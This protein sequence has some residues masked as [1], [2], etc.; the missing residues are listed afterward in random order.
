VNGYLQDQV[1]YTDKILNLN[2]LLTLNDNNNSVGMKLIQ[3]KNLLILIIFVSLFSGCRSSA[4]E[5]LSMQPT[6]GYPWVTKVD[7]I[8]QILRNKCIDTVQ[9]EAGQVIADIGAGNGY[10]E[11]MLSIFNDSLTFYIQDIDSSVC[12]QRVIDEVTEFYEEVKGSPFSNKFIVVNGTDSSTNLPP[13]V[14]DKIFMFSTY[15]YIKMPDEFMA[16]VRNS[17]KDDGILYV[18]N[19]NMDDPEWAEKIKREYGWNA[20][21]ISQQINDIT[22]AGFKLNRL[23][24]NCDSPE[25]PYIM[26]F[27]R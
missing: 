13:A 25:K 5:K 26:L 10:I 2:E 16:D 8:E 23:S 17:L 6:D 27:S 21:N 11:A 7:D 22:G 15:Q 4:E 18:I 3:G 1:N 24:H 9:F 20:S 14:F 12:N 19:P